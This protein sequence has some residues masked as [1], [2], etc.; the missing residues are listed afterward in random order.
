MCSV[1]VPALTLGRTLEVSGVGEDDG[2]GLRQDQDG[3]RVAAVA[4]VKILGDITSGER[5]HTLNL[6]QCRDNLRPELVVGGVDAGMGAAAN[7]P[8]G[9]RKTVSSELGP[10]NTRDVIQL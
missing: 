5:P 7:N 10:D 8:P 9:N 3:R 1:V 4:V 6:P 2:L